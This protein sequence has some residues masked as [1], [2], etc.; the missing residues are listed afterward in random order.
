MVAR[1][2]LTGPTPARGAVG[3]AARCGVHVFSARD[4]RLWRACE[5]VRVSEG[6]AGVFLGELASGPR[7]FQPVRL[8]L[9]YLPSPTFVGQLQSY[10]S[11]LNPYLRTQSAFVL[12]LCTLVIFTVRRANSGDGD[13]DPQT[14]NIDGFWQSPST[15]LLG[16]STHFSTWLGHGYI[17]GLFSKSNICG[18]EHFCWLQSYTSHLLVSANSL[19][20]HRIYVVS[21]MNYEHETY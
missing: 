6:R 2:L 1:C 13:V 10:V 20:L 12:I 14:S 21:T 17:R 5:R 18:P 7:I 9:A 4:E 3:E 15:N 16:W 11:H 19:S 8:G